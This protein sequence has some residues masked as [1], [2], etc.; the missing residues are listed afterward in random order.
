MMRI[1]LVVLILFGGSISVKAQSLLETTN[2][3]RV[4]HSTD[5]Y[6]TYRNNNNRA[7][8]GGYG[9]KLGDTAPSGTSTPGLRSGYNSGYPSTNYNS[10][11]SSSYGLRQNNKSKR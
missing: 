10:G 5:N 3:A 11:G 2:D 8:L 6:N 1:F 9:S 7:P 4:R